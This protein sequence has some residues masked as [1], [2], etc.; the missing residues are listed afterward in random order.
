MPHMMACM[1]KLNIHYLNGLRCFP[2]F[3]AVQTVKLMC[4]MCTNDRC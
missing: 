1:L 3:G 2:N 4:D